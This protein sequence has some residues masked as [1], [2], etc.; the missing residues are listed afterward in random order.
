MS[1][2]LNQD[3]IGT[4]F[5]Q[6]LVVDPQLSHPFVAW[7]NYGDEKEHK[8]LLADQ[9]AWD[10]KMDTYAAWI[11][12]HPESDPSSVIYDKKRDTFYWDQRR[13]KR[14]QARIDKAWSEESWYD[15][16]S[17]MIWP[18]EEELLDQVNRDEIMEDYEDLQHGVTIPKLMKTFL[19]IKF[20][21]NVLFVAI[22][23]TIW[24]WLLWVWN[25]V[26]NSWLNKGWAEG[27]FWLLG[28]TA[29]CTIQTL[30]TVPLV[31]EFE[32]YLRRM[33]FIRTGSLLAAMAYNFT[34]FLMLADWF[35]NIYGLTDEKI[36]EL[37]ALDML[38]NMF[39][40]YNSILH[41]GI[42]LVNSMIIFK[43]LE[44]EFYQIVKG[45]MSAEYALSIDLA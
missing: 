21:W 5:A 31:A 25:I 45:N 44:L 37:G 42:V 14:E 8:G 15:K 32:F 29:F 43:E 19:A 28:N 30:L 13:L 24:A 1:L 7:D 11:K 4:A 26:F 33:F 22:P 38:M 17:D 35:Y 23:W 36:E 34:Y 39:F 16:I 18:V 41:S 9:D 10:G 12:K 3:T 6:S 40:I 27:N 20:L 2:S